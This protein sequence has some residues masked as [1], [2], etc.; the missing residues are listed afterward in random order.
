MKK[1]LEIWKENWLEVFLALA[2]IFIFLHFIYIALAFTL[3]SG[4]N[5]FR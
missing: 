1:I 4:E 2:S 5:G 3:Y